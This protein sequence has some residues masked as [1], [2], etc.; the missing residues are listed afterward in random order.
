MRAHNTRTSRRGYLL[1][2]IMIG[3]ALAA[4]VI[5]GIMTV[6]SSARTRN[7]HATRDVVASQIVLD[8]LERCRAA[9]FAGVGG[10]KCPPGATN[11]VNNGTNYTRTVTI[12]TTGSPDVLGTV[13]I[14]FKDVTVT[15]TY[16]GERFSQTPT[17]QSQAT[18]RIYQ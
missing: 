18:T 6:L 14:P 3:G 5:A 13:S 12:S 15:V 1:I 9:G 11:V 7:V 10:A 4:V 16:V 2:D 17:R 8:Q